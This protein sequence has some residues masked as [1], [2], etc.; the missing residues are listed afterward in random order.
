[1]TPD[2]N[3]RRTELVAGVRQVAAKWDAHL[4]EPVR[5][6]GI[7][8]IQITLYENMRHDLIVFGIASLLLFT[9]AFLVAYRRLRF[10]LIPITCCLLPPV[11]MVGGMAFFGIPIGF[12]TSNMPVLLFVLMLPYSVYFIERYRERRIAA[13]GRGR[14]GQHPRRAARH[15]APLRLLLRHHPRRLRRP[16]PQPD[17]P[18]P[19]LR[20]D[21]DDRHRDSA[22]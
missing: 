3:T 13:P 5:L 1:M 7:P 9:L 8:I 10:V 21:H 16:R 4:A 15:R 20:P 22:S 14:A 17:H 12:V 2:I 18:D 19:R 11:A 6:S